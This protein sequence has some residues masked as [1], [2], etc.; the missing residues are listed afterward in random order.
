MMRPAKA[1]LSGVPSLQE[2]S[3][4]RLE[5]ACANHPKPPPPEAQTSISSERMLWMRLKILGHYYVLGFFA[6]LMKTSSG[7]LSL[8]SSSETS[9]L[10]VC[11]M[12]T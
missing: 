8:A 3:K 2:A 5:R 9:F 12:V 1:R 7:F 4:Q 6:V 11:V 10:A